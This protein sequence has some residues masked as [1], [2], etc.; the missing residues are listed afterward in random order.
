MNKVDSPAAG[1]QYKVLLLPPNPVANKGGDLNIPNS[2]MAVLE[3][4]TC[5]S[6][7]DLAALVECVAL[8]RLC[9]HIEASLTCCVHMACRGKVSGW[10]SSP[11]KT[12]AP[13]GQETSS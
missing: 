6:C 8:P 10:V 12:R 3:V 13:P 5:P 2:S 11:S 4:P 1:L 7:S 9:P